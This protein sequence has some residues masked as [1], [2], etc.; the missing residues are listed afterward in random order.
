[1]FQYYIYIMASN[2][3]TLYMGVTNNLLKRVWEHKED[4]NEGFTK[5]YKCHKLVYY[6]EYNDKSH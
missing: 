4:I 3:G 2:S 1:M 5:K 6:E